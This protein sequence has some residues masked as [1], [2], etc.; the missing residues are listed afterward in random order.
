MFN[1]SN[2]LA[3]MKP[4]APKKEDNKKS[5]MEGVD[6]SKPPGAKPQAAAVSLSKATDSDEEES[7]KVDKEVKS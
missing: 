1:M 6:I 4:A 7:K 2:P 3:A 5:D